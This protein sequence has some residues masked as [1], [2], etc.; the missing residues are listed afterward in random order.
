MRGACRRN[1]EQMFAEGAAQNGAKSVCY[2][3]PVRM[4]CLS[5]AL[6]QR[7]E[8]GVWGG[9]TER[10]R[11]ALLRRHPGVSSWRQVLEKAYAGH[12][13]AE[14]EAAARDI[15]ARLEHRGPEAA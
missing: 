2:R 1:A 11:R 14:R 15:A 4:E 8:Y 9:M 13:A 7:M 3:C 5:Y 6:D 12:E 10:E